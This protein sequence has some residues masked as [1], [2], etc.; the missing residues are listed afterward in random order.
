METI[1]VLTIQDVAEI[2]DSLTTYLEQS[3]SSLAILIDKGGNIL[4]QQG[5]LDIGDA[6]IVAALAAGSFAATKELARRIGEQEFSA[7]YNQGARAHIFMQAVD[8]DTILVTVFGGNT[9]IGL[10]RF[11]STRASQQLAATMRKVRSR[12]KAE[13]F[14]FDPHALSATGS[15]FKR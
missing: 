11:Y 1:P 4:S 8:D 13:G 5:T 3:E 10:V 12:P 6:V 2:D 14:A 9:T 15:L 7:L